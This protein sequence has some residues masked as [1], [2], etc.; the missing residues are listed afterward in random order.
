MSEIKRVPEKASGVKDSV[1]LDVKCSHM[2]FYDYKTEET[3]L[4]CAMLASCECGVLSI[5]YGI[6]NQKQILSVRLDEVAALVAEAVKVAREA[7]EGEGIEPKA[8]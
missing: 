5:V 8:K 7:R 6:D 1:S 3:M 2:R 4:D